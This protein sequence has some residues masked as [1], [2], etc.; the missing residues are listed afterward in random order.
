MECLQNHKPEPCF[1]YCLVKYFYENPD[2]RYP[3]KLPSFFYTALMNRD[4]YSDI[5]FTF[6]QL[7]GIGAKT[8]PCMYEVTAGIYYNE[9]VDYVTWKISVATKQEPGQWAKRSSVI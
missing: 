4:K 9:M 8:I 2:S 6:E 1:E 5:E 7:K 3:D